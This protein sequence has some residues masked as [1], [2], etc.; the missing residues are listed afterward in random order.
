[1]L[2][3][4]A[5]AL[6]VI[7]GLGFAGSPAFAKLSDPENLQIFRAVQRQVL[8]YAFFTIFDNVEMQIDNGVVTLTGKVTQPFKRT[9]IE[10]RVAR[11]KGV[12]EVRNRIDVLPVS[13]FDDELRIRLANAIYGHSAFIGYGSAANP[14]IHIIVERGRVTLEGVVNNDAD[15]L[16][17]RSI[18]SSFLAFEVKDELQTVAEAR[19]ELERL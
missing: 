3:R 18:A 9:D 8:N 7:L 5:V 19:E 15:R 11:V 4:F 1:M 13:Q 16:L 6:A 2:K 17:V 10:R 14:P 12:T